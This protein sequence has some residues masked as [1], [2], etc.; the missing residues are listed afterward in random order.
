MV[1]K[2]KSPEPS[3][4]SSP[5]QSDLLPLILP[6]VL[7]QHK[8]L[9]EKKKTAY[10]TEDSSIR[11][12]LAC[13]KSAN[14][15]L[16]K[17]S[18]KLLQEYVFSPRD[19]LSQNDYK[20][21]VQDKFLLGKE[22]HDTLEPVGRNTELRRLEGNFVYETITQIQRAN[23][24]SLWPILGTY[25]EVNKFNSLF[26]TDLSKEKWSQ[27]AE[28]IKKVGL[29]FWDFLQCQQRVETIF[30]INKIQALLHPMKDSS[31]KSIMFDSSYHDMD[32]KF[33]L[34]NNSMK[35]ILELSKTEM[36]LN[37]VI[38][39]IKFQ[40]RKFSEDEPPPKRTNNREESPL[41]GKKERRFLMV[42]WSKYTK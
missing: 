21:F 12:S 39:G 41:P 22:F 29:L 8:S 37:N 26:K 40:E 11:G 7:E 24:L 35:A 42:K 14:F 27:G 4:S 10:T 34:S 5:S 3:T 15:F 6:L 1:A 31:K 32:L 16:K 20:A 23:R 28:G 38:K 18:I 2:Q 30:R 33:L 19:S 13:S 9:A 36:S 17:E 25:E